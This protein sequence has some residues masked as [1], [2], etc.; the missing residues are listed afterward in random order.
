[1]SRGFLNEDRGYHPVAYNFWERPLV[2]LERS[3]CDARNGF[4]SAGAVIR[5]RRGSSLSPSWKGPY[6]PTQP[7]RKREPSIP[8]KMYTP[9]STLRH[10]G[11]ARGSLSPANAKLCTD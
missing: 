2:Y 7:L 9:L 4:H 6:P 3:G 1:M 5:T 8:P 10:G 11:T